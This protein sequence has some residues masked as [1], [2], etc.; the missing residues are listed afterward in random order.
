M[1]TP[2]VF[3][4]SDAMSDFIESLKDLV[5]QKSA[6][7]VIEGAERLRDYPQHQKMFSQLQDLTGRNICCVWESLVEWRHL[8]PPL[9]LR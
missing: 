7:I 4:K 1:Q 6:V 5:G 2:R 9:G 3:G 8:I